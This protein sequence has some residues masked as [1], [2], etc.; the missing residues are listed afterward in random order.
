MSTTMEK[1]ILKIESYLTENFGKKEFLYDKTLS[2]DDTDV[3][4]Y[5]FNTIMV[6]VKEDGDKVFFNPLFKGVNY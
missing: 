4:I 5:G 2:K 1:T 6:V 3:E